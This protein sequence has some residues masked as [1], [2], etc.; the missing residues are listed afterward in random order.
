MQDQDQQQQVDGGSSSACPPKI[1]APLPDPL[2]AN[3]GILAARLPGVL[4]ERV[5]GHLERPTVRQLA[6]TGKW[7]QVVFAGHGGLSSYL[8]LN[9]WRPGMSTTA[10]ARLMRDCDRPYS[11]YVMDLT[12]GEALEALPE[13]FLEKETPS[14]VLELYLQSTP[15]PSFYPYNHRPTYT[16]SRLAALNRVI[17]ETPFAR[18]STLKVTI[19]ATDI[20]APGLQLV[21]AAL[22]PRVGHPVPLPVL[23]EL[24]LPEELENHDWW[25]LQNLILTRDVK[26]CR[27]LHR[28][29]GDWPRISRGE[30]EEETETFCRGLDRLYGVLGKTLQVLGGQHMT[31]IDD[32]ISKRTWADIFRNQSTEAL[33]K[34]KLFKAADVT[35]WA[36]ALDEGVKHG[37][38]PRAPAMY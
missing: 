18:L 6:A 3:A 15:H 32:Y 13:A 19:P 37:P 5:M 38:Q 17:Q 23:E 1:P 24:W 11:F 25:A 27:G 16:I 34:L 33:Q 35:A 2:R 30:T 8:K 4:L 36:Q 22:I 28:L 29:Y 31:P 10:L 21:F 12:N 7:A 20:E 26:G 9:P 14:N